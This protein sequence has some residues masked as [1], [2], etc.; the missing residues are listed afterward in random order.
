M[1]SKHVFLNWTT[2]WQFLTKTTYGLIC[3]QHFFSQHSPLTLLFFFIRYER[4]MCEHMNMDTVHCSGM[5][6]YGIYHF[7]DF[8][9]I[10]WVESLRAKG[11]VSRSTG[12]C[13]VESTIPCELLLKYLPSNSSA[14]ESIPSVSGSAMARAHSWSPRHLCTLSVDQS[15]SI[16]PPILESTCDPD[17]QCYADTQRRPHKKRSAALRS[18]QSFC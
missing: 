3:C 15:R 17:P 16:T 12:V 11:S 6:S 4:S 2:I 5:Q 13:L 8:G 1:T 10:T 18:W 7:C 9:L 14:C